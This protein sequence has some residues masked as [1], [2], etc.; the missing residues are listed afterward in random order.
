MRKTRAILSPA[1]E[2]HGTSRSALA[3]FRSNADSWIYNGSSIYNDV[4]TPALQSSPDDL[5]SIALICSLVASFVDYFNPRWPPIP[6]V[7]LPMARPTA[8]SMATAPKV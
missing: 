1:R 5:S 2:D 6:M 4:W 3:A 8:L 7:L